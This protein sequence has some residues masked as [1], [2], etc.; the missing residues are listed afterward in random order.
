MGLRPPDGG[1]PLVPNVGIVVGDRDVLVVDTAMGSGTAPRCS[2]RCE[3]AAGAGCCSTRHPLPP[4]A[5]LR[6]PGV[7]ARGD[8]RLQPRA[9]RRAS[10]KGGAYVEMFQELGRTSLR[11]WRASSSSSRTSPTTARPTSTSAAERLSSGRGG[12]PTRAAT[13][14]SS[15][16]R[17]GSSSPATSS[18]TGSSRSSRTSRR[19][20]PTS[21][22]AV[23]RGA[24]R[25]E[26]LEPAIVVPG[27]GEVGD[28]GLISAAHE[29]LTLV[30]S[31]TAR[32]AGEGR[33][34]RGRGGA[35]ARAPAPLRRLGQPGVDR[36]RDPVLLRRL[37]AVSDAIAEK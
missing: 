1:V 29:Y 19:T 6:R 10:R 34:R 2:A 23:D 36:L 30:R 25:L 11:R 21:T 26:E 3:L 31:E 4:R 12:S 9:A 22:A 7:R 33:R 24:R 28:A 27:H 14:S 37:A 13:R 16:P 8:D 18:R 15:C 17:S 20:T 32:L 35:R 5:R